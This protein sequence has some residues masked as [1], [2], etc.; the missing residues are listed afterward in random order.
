[1]IKKY[2]QFVNEELD[3][4]PEQA[5]APTRETPT[6]TR[7]DTDRPTR[8]RPTRPGVIPDDVIHCYD[9]LLKIYPNNYITSKIGRE[10]AVKH[11][12]VI[13][14]YVRDNLPKTKLKYTMPEFI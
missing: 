4:G 7:P 11:H 8:E 6:P 14:K 3:F 12:N 5:P 2:N 1:M 10:N 13:V 9:K